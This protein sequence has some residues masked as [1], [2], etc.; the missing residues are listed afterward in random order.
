[1]P[2]LGRRARERRQRQIVA[3]V[4]LA[5]V[6]LAVLAGV[7][8]FNLARAPG[9]D[10]ATMCPAGG[11]RGQY[12]L[13]VD[14]TDPLTFTQHEAYQATLHELVE[15]RIPPGFLVTVFVLGADFRSNAEPLL[16]LCNPGTGDDRSELTANV[17]RLHRQ[18]EERFLKPLLALGE[19]LVAT[20]PAA[21]S[22]VF[23]MLQLVGLNGFRRHDVKGERRLVIVSDLLHNTPDF[24]MYREPAPDFLGFSNTAYGRKAQAELPGVDVELHVLLT[25]PKLQT[26]RQMKFWEDYFEKAGARI[27]EVRPLEG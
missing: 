22:P 11:P 25:A 12:V 26:R 14:T 20:K 18:Y 19:Q 3:T 5:A 8:W 16:E 17:K 4:A 6:A 21:T 10:K 9:L 7:V 1:M 23:E 24:T 13:L 27:V 2:A 15:R